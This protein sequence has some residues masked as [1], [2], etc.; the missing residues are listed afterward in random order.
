MVL[1]AAAH[2]SSGRCDNWRRIVA[3]QQ[4]SV[5]KPTLASGRGVQV[6]LTCSCLRV[7]KDAIPY[8]NG[9]HQ[10]ASIKVISSLYNLILRSLV[11]IVC[12]CVN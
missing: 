2:Q 10:G 4:Q 5:D 3:E 11:V 7:S 6:C 9:A 1:L 12:I 8:G